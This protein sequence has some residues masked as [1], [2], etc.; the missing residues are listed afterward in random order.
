MLRN[1]HAIRPW[2][3]VLEPLAG[4]LQLANKLFTEGCAYA[5]G[6]NFGPEDHSV[7]TVEWITDFLTNKWNQGSSFTVDNQ[8]NHPHE[9]KYLKLDISK[10]KAKLGWKPKY[11]LKKALD[12]IV[13]WYSSENFYE[14]TKGQ[15]EEYQNGSE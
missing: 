13:E 1:P 7:Q 14:N 10:A 3:H 11:D 12:L 4:Y 6:W 5:E 15:I 8:S 9:A 2:Q